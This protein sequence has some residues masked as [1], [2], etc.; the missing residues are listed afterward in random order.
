MD[1]TRPLGVVLSFLFPIA[2]MYNWAINNEKKPKA[3]KTYLILGGAGI[4]VYS[5]YSITAYMSKDD[6]TDENKE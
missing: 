4:L 3:A 2:G 6:K 1:E 5:I